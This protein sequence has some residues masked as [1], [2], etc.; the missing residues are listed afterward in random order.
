MFQLENQCSIFKMETQ[1]THHHNVTLTDNQKC[2]KALQDSDV[3]AMQMKVTFRHV[4][5]RAGSA[6]A[7]DFSHVHLRRSRLF[8]DKRGSTSLHVSWTKEVEEAR[9]RTKT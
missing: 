8:Y 6:A 4:R 5:K 3:Y 7:L 1:N 2:L 9:P